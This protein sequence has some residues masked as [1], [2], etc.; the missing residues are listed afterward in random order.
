MVRALIS[1]QRRPGSFVA[2][3]HMWVESCWFSRCSEGFCSGF[4]GNPSS[5]KTNTLNSNTT[6]IKDQHENQSPEAAFSS[7]RSQFFTMRTHSKPVNNLFIFFFSKTKRSSRKKNIASVTETVVRDRKIRT[8]KNQLD[9]RIRYR[10]HLE[11]NKICYFLFLLFC[12]VI[13]SIIE[14]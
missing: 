8:A 11:K 6:R 2:Q 14:F 5:T 12:S 9:C 13:N 4:S 1:H 3:C 10:T 7:H